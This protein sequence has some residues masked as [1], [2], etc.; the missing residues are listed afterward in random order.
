MFMRLVSCD[1]CVRDV[2]SIY[3]DEVCIV[4]Q[5]CFVCVGGIFCI[6]GLRGKV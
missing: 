3:R 4:E 2:R 1:M 5:V 6:K